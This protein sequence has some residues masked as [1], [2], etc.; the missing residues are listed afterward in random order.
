M[1]YYIIDCGSEM[2]EYAS[3]LEQRLIVEKAHYLLFLTDLPDFLGF[4]QVTED[5]FLD[6][7]KQSRQLSN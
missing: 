4:E 5:M 2:R 1:K 3:L 6:H 7:V